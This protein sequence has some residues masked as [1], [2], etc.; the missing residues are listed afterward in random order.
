LRLALEVRGG[1]ERS[2][3]EDP[4]WRPTVLPMRSASVMKPESAFYDENLRD[5]EIRLGKRHGRAAFRR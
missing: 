2:A 1:V 5:S 3:A 4:A